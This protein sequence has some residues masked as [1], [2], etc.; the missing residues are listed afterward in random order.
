MNEINLENT[1]SK[2]LGLPLTAKKLFD[3]INNEKEVVLNFDGIEFISRS[4]AQ[5]YIYQ[6][7]NS[8]VIIHEEN[9]NDFVDGLLGVVEEDYKETFSIQ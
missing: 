8:K 3:D 7:Y 6:K 4:F 1:F 9:M 2:K 5:E